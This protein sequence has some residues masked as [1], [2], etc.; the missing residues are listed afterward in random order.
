MTNTCTDGACNITPY[1]IR[2]FW[3]FVQNNNAETI[4]RNGRLYIVLNGLYLDKFI[5]E[6]YTKGDIINAKIMDGALHVEAKG[7]CGEISQEEI[8]DAKEVYIH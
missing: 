3:K 8:I 2:K 5:D 6:F 7:L 4:L 1:A